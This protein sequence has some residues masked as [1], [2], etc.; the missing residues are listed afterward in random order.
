MFHAYEIRDFFENV[1]STQHFHINRLDEMPPLPSHIQNPHKHKFYEV[2][3]IQE[4]ETLQNVDYQ[5]FRIESAT[6]F[7]I[8]QGQ[9]H[10]WGKTNTETIKGYRLMFTEDFFLLNHISKNFLFELVFLDNVY[11]YPCI[12]LSE[13]TDQQIFT[14]FDLLHQEYQREDVNQKVLQSLLYLVLTEIQRFASQNESNQVN[15]K[16]LSTYK[17]FIELL[18]KEFRNHLSVNEYADKLCISDKQLNRII[19]TVTHQRVGEVI[20]NRLLLESKRLLTCTD[21]N[22]SQ[23]AD[24]LGFEDS[25]YFARLFRKETSLSPTEFKNSL[26]EM[27]RKRS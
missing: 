3:L 27:Y 11:F 23:I 15:P 21:L 12:S 8:S 20:K 24:K 19:Q 13:K 25:A 2:L 6:L 10:L 17:E 5:E 1:E 4:G 7:F 14:Y 26:S 9:L 18:E 16:H 22:I